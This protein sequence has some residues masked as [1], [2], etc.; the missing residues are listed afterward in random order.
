MKQIRNISK[1][2]LTVVAVA[3]M[4]ACQPLEGDSWTGNSKVILDWTEANPDTGERPE[5]ITDMSIYYYPQTTTKETYKAAFPGSSNTYDV[6]TETYDILVLQDSPLYKYTDKFATAIFELPTVPEDDA[7]IRISENPTEQCYFGRL[8][9]EKVDWNVRNDI[10]ID[11]ERILKKLNFVIL[12]GDKAELTEPCTVDISG[13]AY[14]K[15]FQNKDAV[16]DA[17]A[18]Q[19]LEIYRHGRYVSDEYEWTSYMGSVYCLGVAGKNILY[20][21]FTDSQGVKQKVTYDVTQYLMGWNT[22]EE[23]IHL[24]I[25]L[26]QDGYDVSLD[27][28]DM[29]NTTDVVFE[30]VVI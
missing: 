4:G 5:Q 24:R 26:E 20:F 7:E 19:V 2:L 23:T 27:G 13:M 9:G 18:I 1:I 15:S 16:E 29:G 21:T 11:M 6:Q 25:K 28:W 22:Y 10:H 8:S 30:Y 14:K 12:I 17:Q 3:S